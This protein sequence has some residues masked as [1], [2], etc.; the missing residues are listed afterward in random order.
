MYSMMEEVGV[1]LKPQGHVPVLLKEVVDYVVQQNPKTILD[2]CFGG[3]GHTRA[4]LENTQA[5]VY[6]VDRDPA[7]ENRAQALQAEYGDRFKF[8]PCNYSEIDSIEAVSFDVIFFDLGI[9]SFHVDEAD[10]GFS[11]NKDAPLDMRM[12]TRVGLSAAEFLEKAPYDDIALAVREYGEEK[13]WKIIAKAL[14]DARGTG[15]LSRTVSLARLIEEVTPAR[16]R[17]LKPGVHPATKSFQGI[18]MAVNEELHH[19]KTALPKAFEMLNAAG[20]L[21][22]ISFHSLEDRIVKR[23]FRAWSGYPVDANDSTPKQDRI[24]L[25][26]LITRKPIRP[27]EAEVHENARSRSALM[28]ILRK[29]SDRTAEVGS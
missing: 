5:V 29:L 15:I 27:S 23:Q 1:S 4:F 3:G 18:R 6:A 24:I 13:N 28:R 7:A 20:S 17:R 19:L 26:D 10:R 14:D 21:L 8:F 25:A 11:F 2:C 22:V 9:S 16:V 12:D